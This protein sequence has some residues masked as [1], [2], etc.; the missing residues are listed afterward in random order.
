M[1]KSKLNIIIGLMACVFFGLSLMFYYY[2]FEAD[3]LLIKSPYVGYELGYEPT[4]LRPS[5][6]C[7]T[8]MKSVDTVKLD[9]DLY[10]SKIYNIDNEKKVTTIASKKN[11]LCIGKY[12]V[13]V[14]LG[15]DSKKVMVSVFDTIKPFFT[16]TY[17]CL[18]L[19]EVSADTL[20]KYIV[21]EDFSEEIEITYFEDTKNKTIHLT[22]T[23]ESR[24]WQEIEVKYELVKKDSQTTKVP[25]LT[26]KSTTYRFK[27]VKSIEEYYQ[28]HA[29]YTKESE[30]IR[31]KE[32]DL[33]K[34]LLTEE[35]YKEIREELDKKHEELEKKNDKKTEI[36]E[37]YKPKKED[38]TDNKPD[39][40]DSNKEDKDE[41]DN[42]GDTNIKQP[43]AC[44]DKPPRNYYYNE[45]TAR[46][47][48]PSGYVFSGWSG[49]K[50]EV[51]GR[52]YRKANYEPKKV[53]C[54]PKLKEGEYA[55]EAEARSNAKYP[56]TATVES[57]TGNCGQTV[58]KITHKGYRTWVTEEDKKAWES[59]TENKRGSTVILRVKTPIDTDINK[60]NSAYMT[61]LIEYLESYFREYKGYT[62]FVMVYTAN[63]S[64]VAKFRK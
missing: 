45:S 55:T 5:K 50:V 46:G 52:I 60:T 27:R 2:L 53:A 7:S 8:E 57:F 54:E 28:M 49:A 19:K 56:E 17:D 62:R 25:D 47:N 12:S 11:V 39:K 23:D 20:S 35:Q 26:D 15:N 37:Q 4:I 24:N 48:A 21:V 29:N 33:Q 63:D 38:N 9:G 43:T 59:A 16:M 61:A 10:D 34:K 18:K 40:D 14:S 51:C 36:I 32:D 3:I 64:L 58:Y 44:T 1:R 31:K 6:F 41:S 22:A 30:N 42:Q 13:D